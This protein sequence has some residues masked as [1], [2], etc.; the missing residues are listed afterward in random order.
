M[1]R[2]LSP[3]ATNAICIISTH[4]HL[5]TS[6]LPLSIQRAFS[7]LI[8]FRICLC[9]L[10]HRLSSACGRCFMCFVFDPASV[11]SPK[12][13]H[14][15]LLPQANERRCRL[16]GK[17]ARTP[18]LASKITGIYSY[19]W[20]CTARNVVMYTNSTFFIQFTFSEFATITLLA[21]SCPHNSVGE[22][23]MLFG[24]EWKEPALPVEMGLSS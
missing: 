22:K 16:E 18:T 8:A 1:F 17:R 12:T 9:L 14:T 10:I 2:A 20:G 15:K 7:K 24:S 23:F 5:V 4:P 21:D 13:K 19:Q 3:D 11:H 6:P